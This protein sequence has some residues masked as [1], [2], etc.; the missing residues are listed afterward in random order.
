M[1]RLEELPMLIR[2]EQGRMLYELSC[3]MLALPGLDKGFRDQLAATAE[4]TREY[5]LSL[6]HNHVFGQPA[7]AAYLFGVLAAIHG[8]KE[9]IK[10]ED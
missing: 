10:G 5:L 3:E 1:V 4:A 8:L 2:A 7:A 9:D 6:L